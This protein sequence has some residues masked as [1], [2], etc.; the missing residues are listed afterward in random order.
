[1]NIVSKSLQNML[2]TLKFCIVLST[3]FVVLMST[4]SP[5]SAQRSSRGGDVSVKPY[6]RKDGTY[7]DGYMRSAPDGTRG[8]NFSTR[9]NINPYT[10]KLGTRS[11]DEYGGGV[12]GGSM[13][14]FR[15]IRWPKIGHRNELGFRLGSGSASYPATRDV[16]DSTFAYGV[17]FYTKQSLT[18]QTLWCTDY[19]ATYAEKN[20][21]TAKSEGFVFGFRHFISGP[22]QVGPYFGALVGGYQ[23]TGAFSPSMRTTKFGGKAVIGAMEKLGTFYELSYSNTGS[24]GTSGFAFQVGLRH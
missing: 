24:N 12:G 19:D 11:D 14:T 5:A 22:A 16:F 13:P 3:A 10:G 8:N 20:G 6:F 18:H 17:S 15:P 7:V 1:M 2:S 4:V 21:S 9:G 23:S